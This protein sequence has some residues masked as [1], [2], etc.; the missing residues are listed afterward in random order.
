[1]AICGRREVADDAISGSDV[2]TVMGNCRMNF[3][4]VS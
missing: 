1:M 2:E 3:E 4:I